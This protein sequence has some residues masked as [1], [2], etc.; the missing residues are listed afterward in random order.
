MT[1]H[2]AFN[3][4]AGSEAPEKWHGVYIGQIALTRN[5]DLW[6]K[7]LVPQLL[8]S[9]LTD[10]ARPMG[11]NT[12]GDHN[13]PAAAFKE[14]PVDGTG[15]LGKEYANLAPLG[16]GGYVEHPQSGEGRPIGVGQPG[17]GETGPGPP[18]GSIVLVMFIAGDRNHPVYALTSQSN[19]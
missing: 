9:T 4:A 5:K 1:Q 13:H 17:G 8:G 3:H 12:I 6:C 7:L 18:G 10:W 2:P 16:W 19:G 15:G 14:I 11:F